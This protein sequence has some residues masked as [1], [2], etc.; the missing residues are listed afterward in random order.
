M[1]LLCTY[2]SDAAKC[3]IWHV[4]H[5]P[6]RYVQT[7]YGPTV[8]FFPDQHDNQRVYHRIIST[9]QQQHDDDDDDEPPSQ[10][11]QDNY[12]FVSVP[13]RNAFLLCDIDDMSRSVGH[14]NVGEGMILLGQSSSSR[15]PPWNTTGKAAA[16][17][18]SPWIASPDQGR[19]L[20]TINVHDASTTL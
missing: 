6:C 1:R 3:P 19:I 9:A 20:L 10:P 8:L 4:D 5:V 2:G 17:H 16:V 18:K 15:S 12:E 13:E 11:P 14:A 7:L